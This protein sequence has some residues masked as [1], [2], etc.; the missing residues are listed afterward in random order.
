MTKFLQTL[1]AI[2]LLV[3]IDQPV[4]AA[5]DLPSWGPLRGH[6]NPKCPPYKVCPKPTIF[7]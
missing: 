1:A 2:A 3:A 4:F 6:A 5:E 7:Y